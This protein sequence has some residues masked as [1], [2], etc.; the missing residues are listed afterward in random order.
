MAKSFTPS[1]Q[2]AN[3]FQWIDTGTGS[4]ILEAV[5]GAGKTTTLING[6]ARMSGSIFF[7]AY[8]KKIADEIR[9]KATAAGLAR[10]GLHI[11]TMHGAGFSAWMRMHPKVKVDE[12]KVSKLIVEMVKADPLDAPMLQHKTFI[13]K[14][15]SFGKQF[16]MGV[17]RPAT[18][19]VVWEKLMDHFSMR[20]ELPENA[21]V[22]L[23]LGY[24]VQVF[25]KSMAICDTVIDFD[26]MIFAPIFHNARM[27]KNDWVLIDECQDLNGA[28][29]ELASRMLKPGGR[30]VAV[31]DSC[32][33]IYGF[34]GAGSDSVALIR[35]EFCCAT[36]PLTV[37]YRCPKA[38]VDYVHQWVSHIQAHPDA[39]QGTVL[40]WTP[41]AGDARPWYLQDQ[42]GASDAILC[43]YTKP[44][45]QTAYALLREGI[46]CKVEGRDIGNGLIK[47][48][49][50][51][52]VLTCNALEKKLKGFVQ[53]EQ[54]KA[55]A[56]GDG[57]NTEAVEDRA[58]TIQIFI[59]RCRAK[60]CTDVECVVEEILALFADDVTGVCTLSTGHKSKGRE[61][62]K[63]YW[64]QAASKVKRELQPWEQQ[65]EK[66]VSY[67]I[68]TRAMDTLML[69]PEPPPAK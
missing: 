5:A 68:G 25:L 31:G 18:H 23:I 26:D 39:P 67:V 51:F 36:L 24:V 49:Q 35:K 48:I 66:N 13:T 65:Q 34:T 40:H 46:A 3:F 32:Q 60:G 7:G 20:D 50:R 43:R 59:D 11:G 37:T 52:H 42:P 69:I 53:A 28:R 63:V 12:R 16:L 62:G 14:M 57:H 38:V 41:A 55:A 54:E 44:L 21:K 64:L 30:L 8:N 61:W 19:L 27:F 29:R 17:K 1:P 47:M 22:Q 6:L 56:A 58:A 45:I 9:S 10:N 15:V 4:A 33:A 2:Q